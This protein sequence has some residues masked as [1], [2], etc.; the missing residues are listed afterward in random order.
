MPLSIFV[1]G[2]LSSC[3]DQ[4]SRAPRRGSKSR[5]LSP[6]RAKDVHGKMLVDEGSHAS[7]PQHAGWWVHSP[8]MTQDSHTCEVSRGRESCRRTRP[9]CS[10]A[11]E[12][13]RSTGRGG[14]RDRLAPN[15]RRWRGR[16]ERR[17]PDAVSAGFLEPLAAG[18]G[19]GTSGTHS[20]R[21]SR[22]PAVVR[23]SDG[24]GSTVPRKV[25]VAN[26]QFMAQGGHDLSPHW[27]SRSRTVRLVL[28]RSCNTP[29]SWSANWQDLIRGSVHQPLSRQLWA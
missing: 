29:M 15:P 24:A 21:S 28:A 5:P 23:R 2:P 18:R 11:E 26:K 12:Q 8:R 14:P 1:L 27:L 3:G 9:R 16:S 6:P 4:A 10:G 13:R 17:A 22:A 19:T 20:S 7:R 25:G